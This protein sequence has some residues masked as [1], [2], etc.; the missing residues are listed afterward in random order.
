M[1]ARIEANNA[2]DVVLK[3]TNKDVEDHDHF[4]DDSIFYIEE[5]GYNDQCNELP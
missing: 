4:H 3:L 2:G 1:D 5:G